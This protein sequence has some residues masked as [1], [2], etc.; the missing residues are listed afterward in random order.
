MS[1]EIN[2]QRT[3]V[4]MPMPKTFGAPNVL[5]KSEKCSMVSMSY[6]LLENKLNIS[7]TEEERKDF[8]NQ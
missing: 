8:L 1:P 2:S 3:I 7:K 5:K 4:A 6:S